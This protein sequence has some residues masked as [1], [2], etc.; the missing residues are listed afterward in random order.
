MLQQQK[1]LPDTPQSLLGRKIGMTRVFTQDGRW[2]DVTLLEA[3][4][5]TVV[6]R[7]TE[8]KDGYDAVQVGFGAV[9]EKRC[10]KP[11]LGHFAKAGVPPART[12]REF[13]IANASELKPGDQIRVDIF[14]KGDHVDISGT[15]KGRGFAGVHKRHGFAGGPGGHGS[16]FHRRPGAIGQS[17]T[18]S[19]TFKNLRMPGHM[20]SERITT[21]NLE[22]IDVDAANNL[23][24]VRGCVPGANGGLVEVKKSVKAAAAK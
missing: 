8:T 1:T 16:T 14:Q 2:I 17:A 10:P 13:R 11:Q 5:C 23:L 7:K 6:Q 12:L 19:R 22:V 15:S 21:Q 4:P 18:P 24:I 20:G 3:G 9:K